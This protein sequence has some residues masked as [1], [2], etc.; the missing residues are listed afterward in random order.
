M[1]AYANRP[2]KLLTLA[3]ADAVIAA[4]QTLVEALTP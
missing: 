2:E 4:M 1:I 3:D